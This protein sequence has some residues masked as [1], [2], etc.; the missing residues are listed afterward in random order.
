MIGQSFGRIMLIIAAICLAILWYAFLSRGCL[1]M[2]GPGGF[3]PGFAC[4]DRAKFL[5]VI[6]SL[7]LGA[8]IVFTVRD[9]LKTRKKT[10]TKSE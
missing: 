8:P 3:S 1:P 6:Y 9:Y 10:K 4:D 2:P 5:I 7:I